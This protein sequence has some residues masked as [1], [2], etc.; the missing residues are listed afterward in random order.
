MMAIDLFSTCQAPWQG[1][2]PLNAP[3]EPQRS[4]PFRP[5]NIQRKTCM[6]WT[7]TVVWMAE[8]RG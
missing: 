4:R 8:H 7:L 6:V 5:E 2:R 3:P 1:V